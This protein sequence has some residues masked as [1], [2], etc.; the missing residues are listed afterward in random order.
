ML[1]GR[2]AGQDRLVGVFVG[3]VAK[4][5]IYP[6][7]QPLGLGDGLGVMAKELGHDLGGLQMPLGMSLQ[8][9][10]GLAQ[11]GVL[12]DAAHHILE[13]P[14]VG[15]VVEDVVDRQERRAG[16]FRRVP[17]AVPAAARRPGRSSWRPRSRPGLR[18]LEQA[19]ERLEIEVVHARRRGQGEEQAFMVVE[20]VGQADGAIALHPP[21]VAPLLIRR[22]RRA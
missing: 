12:A 16:G 4:V 7:R 14:P 22:E 2:L 11:G 19:V 20:Q 21:R 5:R 17:P 8:E 18:G 15:V 3:K 9:T 13:P 1:L 10:A 6:V